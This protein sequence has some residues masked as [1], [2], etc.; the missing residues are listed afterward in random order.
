MKPLFEAIAAKFN[1][2]DMDLYFMEALAG[3]EKPYC[4]DSLVNAAP[5][6]GE[7]FDTDQNDIEIQFSIFTETGTQGL[8]L[9]SDLHGIYDD[10]SLVVPGY[11]FLQMKQR[12][13][14]L[15]PDGDAFQA[16]TTYEILM[17]K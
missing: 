1:H 14:K 2:P 16:I 15:F 10:C 17:D 9:S 5:G 3:I 4:V 12:F 8:E 11:D 7:T 6:L 13:F